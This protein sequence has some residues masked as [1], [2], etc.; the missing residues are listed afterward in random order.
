MGPYGGEVSAVAIDPQTPS[1][2]YV[3]NVI[4]VFVSAN[5]GQ[6]WQFA[7]R[8]FPNPNF[9]NTRIILIDSEAPSTLYALTQPGEPTEAQNVFK[10]SDSGQ[11]WFPIAQ[12]IAAKSPVAVMAIDP[13]HPQI[14]YAAHQQ[15]VYKS[16][17]SGQSWQTAN[18]GLPDFTLHADNIFSVAIDSQASQNLYLGTSLGLFGSSD[19]GNSWQEINTGLQGEIDAI[20]VDPHQPNRLFAIT[21]ASSQDVHRLFRSDDGGSNWRPINA[22][23]AANAFFLH[24][25]LDPSTAGIIYLVSK[26]RGDDRTA[27]IY[28][29][30]NAGMSWRALSALGL[31]QNDDILNIAVDPKRSGIIYAATSNGVYVSH[32]GGH[33]WVSANSGISGIGVESLARDPRML[34]GIL[35]GNSRSFPDNKRRLLRAM[36]Q[37]D[38]GTPIAHNLPNGWISAIT[39]D[40]FNPRSILIGLRNPINE[41]DG[42]FRSIDNGN[43]WQTG[44]IPD[45]ATHIIQDPRQ[46]NIFYAGTNCQID[47]N[48][49]ASHPSGLLYKSNDSGRSWRL[50]RPIEGGCYSLVLGPHANS[51]QS[52]STLA[53]A[54]D[55][56]SPNKLYTS[57]LM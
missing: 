45:S 56:L 11:H 31:E 19:G 48:P 15:G 46:P 53:I 13:Q 33:H 6:N 12:D 26:P 41:F 23:L 22:G 40:A 5:E 30:Q 3:S 49:P 50:L 1:T 8:I 17:D 4:G 32:D 2:L 47:Y 14:L 54:L 7:G 36:G 27:A 44:S 18:S 21:L 43:T 24:L 16:T 25:T 55:N 20:A 28:K 29:S 39:F 10:S 9:R 51:T 37:D 35:V 52:G 42:L 38:S 34:E 57:E